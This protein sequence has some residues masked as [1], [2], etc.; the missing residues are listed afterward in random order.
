MIGNFYFK[1]RTIFGENGR[2]EMRREGGT[3]KN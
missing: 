2:G 1:F 3:F